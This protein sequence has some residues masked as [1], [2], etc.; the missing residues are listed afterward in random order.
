[1][2]APRGQ[3]IKPSPHDSAFCAGSQGAFQQIRSYSSMR[4]TPDIRVRP[5]AQGLLGV[6]APLK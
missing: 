1:M 2:T 3:S 5:E 6:K 4:H